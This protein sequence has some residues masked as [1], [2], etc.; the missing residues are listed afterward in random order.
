MLK[1]PIR[2]KSFRMNADSLFAEQQ[3][4]KEGLGVEID[5]LCTQRDSEKALLC[6]E[7][8]LPGLEKAVHDLEE[9]LKNTPLHM[10]MMC[11]ELNGIDGF[12]LDP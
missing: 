7:Q 10:M 11:Q 3:K 5:S 1:S 4:R 8:G 9:L 2:N 12:A 6:H